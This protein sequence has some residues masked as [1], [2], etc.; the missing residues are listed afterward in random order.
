MIKLENSKY[1]LSVIATPIGNLSEFNDRAKKTIAESNIIFCEDTRVTKKLLSLLSIKFIDK[2]FVSYHKYNEFEKLNSAIELIKQNRCILVSDAGYPCLS[3]P[4]LFLIKSCYENNIGV[5]VING[6]SSLMHAIAVSGIDLSNFLFIG[7]LNRN[8][9]QR[10]E[11]LKELKNINF[12]II[13]FES[14]H[15]IKETLKNIKD[16][17]GD[18]EICVCRELTKKNETIY[19]GLISNV[20]DE[21]EEKGEFVLVID[22]QHKDNKEKTIDDC[23]LIAK[24]L[25]DAGMKQKE[26]CK[27]SCINT[28][29]KSSDIYKRIMMERNND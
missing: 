8:K 23:L 16:I 10:I 6:S 17:F 4:G 2:K 28:N 15:R 24:K 11:K 27:K 14:V 19:R 21:I 5:E 9:N 26:A 12:P 3:D 22:K 29:Y 1:L 13:I 18:R 7:F 20:I 25:I